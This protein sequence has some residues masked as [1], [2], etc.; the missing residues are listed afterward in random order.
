MELSADQTGSSRSR[1]NELWSGSAVTGLL[2]RGAGSGER[3][4]P[5]ERSRNEEDLATRPVCI[6]GIGDVYSGEH[7]DDCRDR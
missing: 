4:V 7:K 5:G 2:R 1:S 6:Y 3:C